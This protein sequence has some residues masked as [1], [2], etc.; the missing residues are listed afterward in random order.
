[1]SDL[2]KGWINVPIGALCTLENG[3]AFRPEDWAT[4]G[5]PIVRIQNLNNPRSLFNY[6]NRDVD[7]RYL[8]HGGELLF[9]WSGTPG[10]SFG[11]HI[12][13]GGEAVLNQHIFR[14]DFND[15]AIDKRYLRYAINQKLDEL[16]SI[17]HGGVG[18]RHVTKGKFENTEICLAPLNE[19]KR[20]AN[21]LDVMLEQVHACHQ[22]LKHASTDIR[23]FRQVILAVATS[24][25]LTEEWRQIHQIE[26]PVNTML[27]DVVIETSYGSSAK[28]DSTG[29][30]PVLRMGNIQR[31]R[32]DWTDLVYTS[33]PDEIAKYTLEPGDVLFNRTNS[34]ELVGKTAV[35]KGEHAAI[36]AGYLIR[37]KC[38][39]LLLPDYLNYCLNSP[40]GRDWCWR[41]KSDGVSQSNINAR[42]LAEFELLLPSVAEQTEIIHRAEALFAYADQLEARVH[43][44]RAEVERLTPTILA[45][46]FRGELVPQ[47]PNDEPA[48]ALL[49]RIRAAR[50]EAKTR[51]QPAVVLRRPTMP[52]TDRQTAM[53][54][55]ELLPKPKFRFE[56]LYARMPG[57]YEAL[58][59]VVYH[60]L[61]ESPTLF[62][63]ADGH[64]KQIFDR[65]ERAV[66]FIRD[67]Q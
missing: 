38:S 54:T 63:G 9:A 6:Y 50:E 24:G 42:K 37:V 29:A 17:A 57:D 19:Q 22:K 23:V 45:K 48:S 34:P 51:P 1:M 52:K 15:A 12:W 27:R 60:L 20:I 3:R 62:S 5:L 66:D 33:D 18:L 14:V 10:T 40:E 36:Y 39:D 31:G 4:H 25:Q 61:N 49:E 13:V 21:K 46:A 8:L 35:Y 28:S 43:A 44:V 47:D 64:L 41:V 30:I 7:N 32:L 53:Q 11:A 65:E 16:I 26:P 59:D 56:D 2:P 58:K 55:I 67:A